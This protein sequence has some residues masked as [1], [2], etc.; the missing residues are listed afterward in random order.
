MVE[1]KFN[2]AKDNK[3]TS[4]GVEC[5]ESI[6]SQFRQVLQNCSSKWQSYLAVN[7]NVYFHKPDLHQEFEGI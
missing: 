6:S 2:M 7:F 3:C 1:G 5:R 4:F